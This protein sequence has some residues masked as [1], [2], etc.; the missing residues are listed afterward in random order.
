MTGEEIRDIRKSLGLT[1]SELGQL[2]GAHGMTV[3]KWELNIL[4]PTAYQLALLNAFKAAAEK[5]KL[6]KVVKTALIG[7]GIIAALLLLLN[8]SKK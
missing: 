3:S 7:G 6:D 4:V 5:E 2:V 1:Q 8:N